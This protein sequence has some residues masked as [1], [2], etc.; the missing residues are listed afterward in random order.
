MSLARHACLLFLLAISLTAF[1]QTKTVWANIDDYPICT[2]STYAGCWQSSSS[3]AGGTTVSISGPTPTASPSMD[4][5]SAQ[6][7]VGQ[8]SGYGNGLWWANTICC[9]TG[10][11]SAY[12]N[13]EYDLYFYITT[14]SLSQALE[15]DVNQTISTSSTS[16]VRYVFG[17]QCESVVS[18][19]WQVWDEGTGWINTGVHC[20]MPSARWNHVVWDFQRTSSGQVYF[21]SLTFNGHKYYINKQFGPRILNV[22]ADDLNVAFQMDTRS[23]GAAYSTW[24]DEIKLSAW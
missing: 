3:L 23:S 12:S 21:I 24:L 9:T 6:F 20:V 2:G 17:T 22:S 16:A 10:V 15:F 7:S 8:N 5:S 19:Q 4:G 18:N 11:S 13:F 14:P 1:A